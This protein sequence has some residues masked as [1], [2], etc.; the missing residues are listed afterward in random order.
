MNRTKL[1]GSIL[2]AV[3]L[4]S[5]IASPAF[6]GRCSTRIRTIPSSGA[7]LA[8]LFCRRNSVPATIGQLRASVSGG[9][10]TLSANLQQG[11]VISILGLTNDG[12]LIAGCTFRDFTPGTNA[13]SG[14]C[15]SAV[16]WQGTVDFTE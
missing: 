9:V 1:I 4:G 6:A 14:T 15:N 12:L 2:G 10:K 8:T 3:T 7:D 5:L 13:N 11:N 16:K